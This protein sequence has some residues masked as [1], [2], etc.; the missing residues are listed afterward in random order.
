MTG[1]Y[2]GVVTDDGRLLSREHEFTWEGIPLSQLV[3]FDVE[4]VPDAENDNDQATEA[5]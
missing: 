5:A 1:L 3:W 4:S 2:R